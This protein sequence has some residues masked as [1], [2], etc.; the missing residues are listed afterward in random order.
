MALYIDSAFLDDIIAAYDMFPLDGVTLNPTIMLAA[1]ERGQRLDPPTL[2]KEL[3]QQ[4]DGSI[5]M[6]PGATNKDE[7]LQE[8]QSYIELTP[9]RIIAKIPMTQDG[10]HVAQQLKRQNGR[11]AFT[12]VT[13]LSQAYCAT[14]VHA[15]FIIPYYNR[16]ARSGIDPRERVSQM[17]ALMRSQ[18][19]TT[20][21]LAA[22]IKSPTEAAEAL[23][24]GAQDLT[25]IPG[26][27]TMM[28]SDPESE[29]AV[30][31]FAQDWNKMKTL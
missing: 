11:V 24:S 30:I 18:Q 31:K 22:S 19:S 7:M 9:Q 29:R 13:S 10:F 5:F 20:R 3:L 12:A 4:V 1:Y 15:D 26:V 17:A 8:A 2:L 16:L 23:L 28:A 14:L 25:I 27:L 6:Q 21:I